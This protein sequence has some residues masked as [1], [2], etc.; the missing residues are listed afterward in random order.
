MIEQTEQQISVPDS[1]KTRLRTSKKPALIFAA[2]VG[3][4]LL[5]AAGLIVPCSQTVA[6]GASLTFRA[7]LV[8]PYDLLKGEYLS[9]TYPGFDRLKGIE[10]HPTGSLI[11]VTLNKKND[12]WQPSGITNKRPGPHAHFLRAFVCD[13]DAGKRV[14]LENLE[15]YYV[16]SGTAGT[17]SQSAKLTVEAAV[18]SD[19][20]PI[21][22]R[23]LADGK[24]I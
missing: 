5:M 17:V 2:M 20:E 23:I 11:Y 3:T 13:G 16:Q 8:D 21:I 10:K 7:E 14:R 6:S 24:P 9:L 1:L 12:V 22:K 19:G 15:R 4:Q 18:S